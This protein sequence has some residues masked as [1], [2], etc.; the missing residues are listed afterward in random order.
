MQIEWRKL[1]RPLLFGV[2][3]AVSAPGGCATISGHAGADRGRTHLCA[4]AASSLRVAD[5]GRGEGNAADEPC[6]VGKTTQ[7]KRRVALI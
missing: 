2:S 5:F 4:A 7:G 1:I 6:F 3:L